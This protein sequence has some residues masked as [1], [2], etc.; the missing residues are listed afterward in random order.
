MQDIDQIFK[1][2]MMEDDALDMLIDDDILD[3]LDD[4]EDDEDYYEESVNIFNDTIHTNV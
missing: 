2:D 4:D 3:L 1:E